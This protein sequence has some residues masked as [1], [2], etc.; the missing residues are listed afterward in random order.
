MSN[1]LIDATDV[2]NLSDKVMPEQE[3]R[4]KILHH[5]KQVGCEGDMLKLFCKIDKLMINC[6]NA[7]EREDIG[8]M[9]AY[10][11]WNLLGGGGQLYVG[12]QLIADDSKENK[13]IL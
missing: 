4:R 6:T 3:T 7:R 8:K 10:E 12:G 2:N 5:A 13:I 9:G 11:V 1:L